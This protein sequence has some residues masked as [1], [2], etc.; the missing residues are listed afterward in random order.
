MCKR[1]MNRENFGRRS[2]VII[3]VCKGHGVW[4]ERQELQRVLAFID[5]GG[6]ERSR[7]LDSERLREQERKSREQRDRLGRDV[8]VIKTGDAHTVVLRSSDQ[9]QHGPDIL[10][11][12]LKLLFS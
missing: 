12:A 2:G 3:D 1:V 4:F 11:E 7:A 9:S 5:S 6:L 8:M 10:G